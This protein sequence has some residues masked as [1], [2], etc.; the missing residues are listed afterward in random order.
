LRASFADLYFVLMK[1]RKALPDQPFTV[2]VAY[3]EYDSGLRALE[4]YH[5]ILA[6]WAEAVDFRLIIWKF[7]PLGIPSLLA[8]ATDDAIHADLILVSLSGNHALPSEAAAW[9]SGW[10]DKTVRGPALA[11]LLDAQYHAK[12]H[13]REI[14]AFLRAVAH[15]SGLPFFSS[16]ESTLDRTHFQSVSFSSHTELLHAALHPAEYQDHWGLNE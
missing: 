13:A 15:H 6:H 7:E 3:E 14:L 2:V 9:I 8:K 10:R 11:L 4:L 1:M 5:R 12:L 16:S